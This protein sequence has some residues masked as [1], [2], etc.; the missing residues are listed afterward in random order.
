M[1]FQ[2]SIADIFI[3]RLSESLKANVIMNFSQRGIKMSCIPLST[4]Y[5]LKID[6]K[7]PLHF[8][9]AVQGG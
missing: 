2:K 9:T 3:M 8:K 7:H 1:F 6:K 5:T 4:D